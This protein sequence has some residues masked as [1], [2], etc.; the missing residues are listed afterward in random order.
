MPLFA[1]SDEAEG[2]FKAAQR[3][4]KSSNEE[5]DIDQAIQLLE[6]SV[7]LKPFR[8]EYSKKLTE[9]TELRSKLREKFLMSV[10]E[11]LE[12][13]GG[14]IVAT[15]RVQQGVVYPGAEV[16]IVG[17]RGEKR[18]IVDSLEIFYRIPIRAVPGEMVGLLF[19]KLV[20]DDVQHGDTI[21]KVAS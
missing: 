12:I 8:N 1:K 14:G 21:E 10:E 13:R 6:K 18:V 4:I 11:V 17:P 19:S 2:Y 15:G 5:S 7:M 20:K 9:A 16:R 3:L